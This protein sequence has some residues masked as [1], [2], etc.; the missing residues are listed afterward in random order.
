MKYCL[1]FTPFQP[2]PTGGGS[3][4]RASITLEALTAHYRVI[5]IH[6]ELW[7]VRS[8]IF[9]EEWVRARAAA[10]FR[11]RPD[12]LA[13]IGSLVQ[14]FLSGLQPAAE[15][16]AVFAFRQSVAP[17]AIR[18]F[19]L[20]GAVPRVRI[21][22]LD[23]DECSRNS[24]FIPLH[25]AAGHLERADLLRAE[26]PQMG[27]FRSMLMPRFSQICLANP[28]DC[29]ALQRQHPGLAVVH[30]PNAVRDPGKP[31]SASKP[32]GQR[33][34]FVGSLDYLP[35]EDAI[36]SFV[37]ETLPLLRAVE[38]GITLRVVGVGHSPALE[39]IA[40]WPG[41]ELVGAVRDLGPE[42]AAAAA[43]VVPLRAGSGTRIK[44][45]EA[46]RHGTPVISST[47]GAEGLAVAG[48]EHLLIAD[49]PTEF[50]AACLRVLRN[51]ELSQRLAA[52]G[53]DFVRRNHSIEAV[54]RIVSAMIEK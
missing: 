31:P 26:L 51:P 5:V 32:A 22:D 4:M 33:L 8:G 17:I 28:A 16:D 46:F 54:R 39:K 50:A 10:Y 53:L 6:P 1:F 15:V 48:G 25:E 29:S 37:R 47:K 34:L 27:L 13:G 35:N 38:P 7:A 43:L 40:G 19:A 24:Q 30:L 18:C 36:T 44:I 14:D 41:L 20:A 21:L 9:H 52:N 42:Y 11:I 3:A 45:L 12:R 49:S 2:Y 23:D